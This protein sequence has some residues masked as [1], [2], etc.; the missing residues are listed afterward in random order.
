MKAVTGT[1][2]SL[3]CVGLIFL[4]ELLKFFFNISNI[5]TLLIS[6]CL[7]VFSVTH[8]NI[9]QSDQMVPFIET[10][11]QK[12][13]SLIQHALLSSLRSYIQDLFQQKYNF[14][15]KLDI[16][17]SQFSKLLQCSCSDF[18][19]SPSAV[20]CFGQSSFCVIETV[21][22]INVSSLFLV[23]ILFSKLLAS[24]LIQSHP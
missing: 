16:Y 20:Q 21:C 4:N 23:L 24:H 13:L 9:D 8:R 2:L 11:C 19:F 17:F 3:E 1:C 5:Y 12:I 15:C 10:I 22:F 7:L 6:G 18:W 14:K